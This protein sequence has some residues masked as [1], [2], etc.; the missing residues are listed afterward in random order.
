MLG[1]YRLINTKIRNLQKKKDLLLWLKH[2]LKSYFVSN[3]VIIV[4]IEAG[5]SFSGK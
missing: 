1:R 3:D 2:D 5:F 4:L